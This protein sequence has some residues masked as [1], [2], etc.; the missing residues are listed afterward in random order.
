[1]CGIVHD[2]LL[3]HLFAMTVVRC[4]WWV[5]EVESAAEG[6]GPIACC[7][8]NAGHIRVP[9]ERHELEAK[10]PHLLPATAHS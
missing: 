3:K 7:H 6:G 2:V 10:A 5:S 8:S 1:M 9:C 4:V